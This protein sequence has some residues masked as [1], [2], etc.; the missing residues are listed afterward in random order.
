VGPGQEATCTD[1]VKNGTETDVDCGGS[2]PA[3]AVGP[4]QE[5]T[6][7]DGVKNGT[8]TDVDCGGSCGGTCASGKTC[9]AAGDCKSADCRDGT[10]QAA[11]FVSVV[12]GAFHTCALASSGAVYCWGDDTYGELGSK[13]GNHT[14]PMRVAM[15]AGISVTELAAGRYHTCVLDSSGVAYCWGRNEH[16]ELGDGT[17][18]GASAPRAVTMPAGVSFTQIAPRGD[19]TC[20]LASSGI[21]YCWGNNEHGELGDG[22]T[23]SGSSPE[24]VAMPV[25]VSFTE[26]APG[27]YH[28]CG[29]AASG[30][31]YCWGYNG[32]GELG[33]GTTTDEPAP[34]LVARPVG[35]SFT[36]L[37][38]G[39]AH[40]C[41]L[42]TPSPT[43]WG[44]N[45]FGQLGD[46]TNTNQSTPT[47]VAMPA[48]VSF[49]GLA[50][51]WRHTCAVSADASAYCWGD[52]E[53]GQLGDGT[54]VSKPTPKP[55]TMPAGISFTGLA[56][57]YL[58]TCAVSSSGA[59]YC[60]GDNGNGQLGDGTSVDRLG[61]TPVAMP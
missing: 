53:K 58:H 23:T 40:T 46:G 8:E 3:C 31:A 4:G 30:A 48:G 1:G 18:N 55:V 37:A 10:C 29:H 60:W 9:A 16:G 26:L 39:D 56:A 54:L 52:N 17:T 33:D 21:A 43:C 35:A 19:H 61:P 7:T 38:A 14:A 57:G 13:T 59:A 20:A 11:T 25:G 47:P 12:A 51:G 24:P 44:F 50:L 5:A 34:T 6:C 49:T 36:K 27:Y 32:F 45:E 41:A 2:C 15:P 28:G 22:T 42:G